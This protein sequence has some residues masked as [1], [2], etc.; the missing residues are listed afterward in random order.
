VI[1]LI[2]PRQSIDVHIRDVLGLSFDPSGTLLAAVTAN[3]VSVWN[4]ATRRLEAAPIRVPNVRDVSFSPDR[5]LLAL[6]L[7]SGPVEL[8]DLK[9]HQRVKTLAGERNVPSTV[10]FTPNGSTLVLAE[11]RGGAG[12]ISFWDVGTGQQLGSAFEGAAPIDFSNDGRLLAIM[13]GPTSVTVLKSVLWDN[14]SWMQRRLCAVL[15]RPGTEC[16]S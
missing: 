2:H 15:T 6:A 7:E 11:T 5:K 14:V 9:H 10:A 3:G 16:V 13:N 12:S 1:R 4:L 8:W